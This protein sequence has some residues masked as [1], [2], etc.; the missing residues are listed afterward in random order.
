MLLELVA[1]QLEVESSNKDLAFGVGE[2]YTVF[3]VVSV[4]HAV[5]LDHL[6]VGVRLLDV[7]TVVHHEVATVH[8][9][10]ASVVVVVIPSHVVASFATALV[11][12]C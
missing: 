6:H 10:L 4:D 8:V 1:C 5:F 12:I 11:V 9:S 2:L 7:L 3:G